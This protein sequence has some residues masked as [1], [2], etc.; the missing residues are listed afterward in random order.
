MG[1]GYDARRRVNCGEG[2]GRAAAVGAV[3][4]GRSTRHPSRP[5]RG[6]GRRV[7]DAE[8][9]PR[10]TAPTGAPERSG[11][12]RRTASRVATDVVCQRRHGTAGGASGVSDERSRRIDCWT[13]CGHPAKRPRSRR[14]AAPA[15][16]DQ[17]RALG[18]SLVQVS[19]R[20]G[21]VARLVHRVTSRPRAGWR[22]GR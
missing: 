19:G 3:A 6:R 21:G 18:S 1:S 7:M 5:D 16:Q 17:R 8:F 20:P 13:T 22:P 9:D 14:R 12:A 15:L 4:W 11:V 2:D 10:T